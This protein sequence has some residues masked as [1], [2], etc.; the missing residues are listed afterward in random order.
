MHKN[1]LA[2]T[3]AAALAACG[4]AAPAVTPTP[5]PGEVHVK[6]ST[7]NGPLP[8]PAA[9]D[10]AP[11]A[12]G[13]A[14]VE[15]A[16][17]PPE[18]KPAP[19]P[20]MRP[21]GTIIELK[22]DGE[23]ELLFSTTRGWQPVIFAYTGKPPKAKAVMLFASNCTASCDVP[24]DEVCPVC[25]APT[26]K[27]E[28]LA[29]AKVETAAPGGSVK[30]PWDG[31]VYV[32]EAAPGKKKCKCWRKVDPPAD[33]YTIKACGL[34]AAQAKGK[35]SKPVCVE[36]QVTLGGPDAPHTIALGFGK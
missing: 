21:A 23:G 8:A 27:K 11:V 30:V 31:K 2:L 33:T 5:P 20:V 26:T 17:A 19:R 32:Y 28:E 4:G 7:T 22:N 15:P 12:P 29:M 36:T 10:V 35:A 14:S 6:P 1:L 9:P 18:E 3:V 13:E 34:R 16:P 24:A 25:A